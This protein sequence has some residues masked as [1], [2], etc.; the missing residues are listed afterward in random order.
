MG[1]FGHVRFDDKSVVRH[2]T[3]AIGNPERHGMC[4]KPR[5]NR[6]HARN[7]LLYCLLALHI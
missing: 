7:L 1:Q 5:N 3:V 6:D 4:A 2:D